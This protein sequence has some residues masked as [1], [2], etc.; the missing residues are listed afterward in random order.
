MRFDWTRSVIEWLGFLIGGWLG[1]NVT[2]WVWGLTGLLI[3]PLWLGWMLYRKLKI[4]TMLVG[5]V[6]SVGIDVVI[7][8]R[9]G[10]SWLL[11]MMVIAVLGQ[12]QSRVGVL[13]GVFLYGIVLS[14]ISTGGWR[15]G[16][17]NGVLLLMLVLKYQKNNYV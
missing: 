8:F 11:T 14:L 13:V 2:I 17:I 7:G 12:R 10:L 16:L 6:F 4:T 15:V 9:A 5:L 1:M 3:W